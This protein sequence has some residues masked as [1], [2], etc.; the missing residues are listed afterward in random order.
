MLASMADVLGDD[1]PESQTSRM[2]SKSLVRVCLLRTTTN[3][4][5]WQF[6]ELGAIVAAFRMVCSVD[7]GRSAGR[8]RRHARWRCTTPRKG[9]ASSPGRCWN[10]TS[11]RTHGDVSTAAYPSSPPP[12]RAANSMVI[13]VPPF[14]LSHGQ[15]RVGAPSARASSERRG[16]RAAP[17]SCGVSCSAIAARPISHESAVR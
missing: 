17:R 11:P 5:G 15:V 4:Q 16:R 6:S 12:H 8:N 2:I 3:S 14:Q 9:A 10:V 1:A 7:V 13:S